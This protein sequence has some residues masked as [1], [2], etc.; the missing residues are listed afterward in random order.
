MKAVTLLEK[1]KI[2][3]KDDYKPEREPGE[4]DVEIRLMACGV[5]I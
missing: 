2:A 1:G 4:H 3:I 5:R